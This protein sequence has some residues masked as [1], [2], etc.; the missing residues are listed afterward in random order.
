MTKNNINERSE[1]LYQN[2]VEIHDKILDINGD[3]WR[4]IRKDIIGTYPSTITFNKRIM[5]RKLEN[6]LRAFS[7][8]DNSIKY[9]QGMNFIVGFFLFHC[10][11]YIAFWLFVSLIEEYDLRKVFMGNYYT[12]TVHV[13]RL[14]KILRN[15]Y[16]VY[17]ENFAKI[18]V[19]IDSFIS[20]CVY[21][22]FS[23][24]IPIELLMDFYKGFFSQ[25]WLFFYKVCISTIVNLKGK[26]FEAD[27][28]YIR[29]KN[30]NNKENAKE[31]DIKNSWKK[32]LQKAYTII[33]KTDVYEFIHI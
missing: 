33:T 13:E 18:R 14:N 26:L 17:W 6:V 21:S 5:L 1:K 28:I 10:E 30:G 8:Y 27:E 3:N 2:L 22:L 32:I 11:E 23:S 12:L 15:E 7:N 25:G 16:P 9:C 29:L 24:L 20:E 31:E 4:Q 19:K